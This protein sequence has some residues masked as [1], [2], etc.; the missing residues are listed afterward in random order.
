MK[1][2]PNKL[3]TVIPIQEITSIENWWNKLSRENQTELEVLYNEESEI[4][5]QMVELEFCGEYVER[6]ITESEDAFWI[7]QFYEYLVNHELIVDESPR[8]YV[9]SANN[10]AEQAIRKGVI[11]KD[12]VCPESNKNCLMRKII[13]FKKGEKSLK[14]FVRFK[15]VE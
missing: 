5:N 9:C 6:E 13:D 14:L 7:H 3:K 15:L 4:Q 8:Y 1:N 11:R 10:E 12:F 2:I